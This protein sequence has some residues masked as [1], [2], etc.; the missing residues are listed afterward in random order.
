VYRQNAEAFWSVHDYLFQ[1][2]DQITAETLDNAV[3]AQF[4]QVSPALN[5]DEYSDCIAKGVGGAIVSRDAA[6]A[7]QLHVN[8]TP[9][10]FLNGRRVDGLPPIDQLR[11]MLSDGAAH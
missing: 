3:K 8:A 1:H 9:T 7:A 10:F 6:V 4:K 2:Q 5:E 11:A